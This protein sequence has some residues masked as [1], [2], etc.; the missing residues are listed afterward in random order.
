PA[1]ITLV[2]LL[3]Y[4]QT[5]WLSSGIPNHIVEVIP[6]PLS[7]SIQASLPYRE[8]TTHS[9]RKLHKLLAND[10]TLSA[11]FRNEEVLPTA[12]ND[13]HHVLYGTQEGD[14]GSPRRLLF[15]T[16]E[17]PKSPSVEVR[18]DIDSVL[19]TLEHLPLT[20][21]ATVYPDPPRNLQSHGTH[22]Y[23]RRPGE[24][25][26]TLVDQ[27]PHC[28]F[29][30]VGG[31]VH[32][33][34]VF[35]CF[36]TSV[37]KSTFKNGSLIPIQIQCTWYEKV[38]YPAFSQC[39]S[40]NRISDFSPT[41]QDFKNLH[42]KGNFGYRLQGTEVE[43]AVKAM[44]RIVEGSKDLQHIFSGFF[45][46][47]ACKGVKAATST[48]LDD[49]LDPAKFSPWRDEVVGVFCN[50]FGTYGKGRMQVD[51]AARFSPS[52]STVTE[53][54]PQSLLWRSDVTK[55][56]RMGTR[57]CPT[58]YEWW[59]ASDVAGSVA[60]I[61]QDNVVD[62]S[63][64]PPSISYFQTYMLDKGCIPGLYDHGTGNLKPDEMCWTNEKLR[65]S[66]WG[67][68]EG[69]KRSGELSWGARKELRI[70]GQY[71]YD[72]EDP[73]GFLKVCQT[74]Q[75]HPISYFVFLPSLLAARYKACNLWIIRDGTQRASLAASSNV[76][77]GEDRYMFQ[78]VLLALYRGFH[79]GMRFT[80][81]RAMVFGPLSSVKATSF[82]LGYSIS[83][84]NRPY[85]TFSRV[86]WKNALASLQGFVFGLLPKDS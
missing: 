3:A 12:C 9:R 25:A 37:S 79:R 1:D 16:K 26:P 28:Y 42:P 78:R 35:P 15:E 19:W 53:H 61:G 32:I 86:N 24:D 27:T 40:H 68:V 22:I 34:A 58:H 49:L 65:K 48:S 83:I 51:I 7:S 70:A 20:A 84:Y 80:A 39:F 54:G 45:F 62:F 60:S 36:S 57:K 11:S 21:Y 66:W 47:A 50:L 38:M 41:L 64:G 33:H 5:E 76:G 30:M 74:I 63:S 46:L 55:R 75:R 44:R 81:E 73:L 72:T 59:L 31:D 77:S 52:K 67:I 43:Q 17:A 14:K 71:L 6:P 29:A 85:L 13:L 69:V 2:L 56:M 10:V 18:V 4:L 23:V 82:G 8:G